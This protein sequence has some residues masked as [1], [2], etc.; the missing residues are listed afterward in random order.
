MPSSDAQ[1]TSWKE[2]MARRDADLAAEAKKNGG[3]GPSA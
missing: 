1:H 3:D 2:V